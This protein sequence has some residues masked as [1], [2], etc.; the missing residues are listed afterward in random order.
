M[1]NKINIQSQFILMKYF[2]DLPHI[3]FIDFNGIENNLEF[4][5]TKYIGRNKTEG[6]EMILLNKISLNE[7]DTLFTSS[8]LNLF[9]SK[10]TNVEG[11]DIILA[12][13]N[14]MPYVL[15]KEVEEIESNAHEKI[16]GTPLLIDGTENWVFL[17]FCKR[18][19]CSIT[20]S[21]DE[22]GEWGEIR[23]NWTGNGIIGAVAEKRADIGVGALY[24][25]FHESLF[26]SLSKPI[27]RTGVTCI[28]PKPKLIDP[29]S[30]PIIPFS[31]TLWLAVVLSLI[32]NSIFNQILLKI[33]NS[34]DEEK[35]ESFIK[36]FLDNLSI[37]VLQPVNIK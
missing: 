17:E 9:P 3:L 31:S 19:N 12:I 1:V 33:L 6:L 37:N 13:F 27:S 25:W 28:T 8:K 20:I 11:R 32:I 36:T 34:F 16:N 18:I 21:L 4:L 14:Y 15:W 26:L 10:L 22:A 23:D 7:I 2:T 5:T 29:I 30:T 35:N 24:S